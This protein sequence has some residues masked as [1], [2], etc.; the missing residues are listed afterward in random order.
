L[1]PRLSEH[2]DKKT[3]STAGKN[4]KLKYFEILNSREA[5]ELREA[6][7]KKLNEKNPREIRKM[8]ISFQ[9]LIKE[10]DLG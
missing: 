6:E 4:P 5:A 3:K 9:D 7:L 1:R 2:I 10:V 8:V